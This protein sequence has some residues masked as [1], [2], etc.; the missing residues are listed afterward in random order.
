M[1]ILCVADHVDPLVYSPLIKERFG[2]VDMVLG[3]GD[4]PMEYLGY[5][6]SCLNKPVVFVFGNHHLKKLTLFSREMS[7][8]SQ[9][10]ELHPLLEN[11]YGAIHIGGRAA[12]FQ[13][14]LVAGLGGCHRYNSEENQFTDF[15]MYLKAF[16]LVPHLIWNRLV[17]GRYVDILLTHASPYGIHDQPD[18][19]HVGFKAFLWLMRTFKPRFLIHGHI[20]LYDANSPRATVHLE[21]K[22]VNAYDHVVIDIEV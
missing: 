11:Y 5:I 6:S 10:E 12:R 14:L 9:I 4:L 2:E 21:T 16:R 1:R 3:A 15:Q 13:K 19:C 7:L 17:H 18:P 8:L 20:H 22:V